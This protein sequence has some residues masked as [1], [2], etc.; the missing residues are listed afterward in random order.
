MAVPDPAIVVGEGVAVRP[1]ELVAVRV[2]VPVKPFRGLTVI[3]AVPED[4]ASRGPILVGLAT[5]E[6]S[7]TLTVTIVEWVSVPLVPVTVTVKVPTVDPE[8]VS[9][10]EPT[11]LLVR[12]T[13]GTLS[14]AERPVVGLTDV[15]RSTVPAKPFRLARLIVD[16]PLDPALTASDD[17]L[18]EMLKS[19][20]VTVTVT[21]AEW[22]NEPLVPVTVT[23]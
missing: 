19:G 9:M 5:I 16:T 22:D 11:P 6:K 1:G 15:I 8:T 2:T 13:E 3:V 17:G 21:I 14:V 18:E 7:T 12:V 4:P 20:T 23:A 10:A